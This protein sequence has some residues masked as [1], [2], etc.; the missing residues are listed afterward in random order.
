VLGRDGRLPVPLPVLVP[1]LPVQLIHQD[2][3]G[4]ALLQCVVGAGPPGA[5]NIAADDLMTV[6]E[7]VRELGLFVIPL[8][9]GPAHGLARALARL[10]ALP[11]VA[12][13]VEAASHPAVMDTTRAKN[14]LGWTPRHSAREALRETFRA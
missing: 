6:A 9:A 8:P 14:E 1:E 3:V 13:W 7:V 11:T 5:Y 10:P 2:D 12:G 4:S